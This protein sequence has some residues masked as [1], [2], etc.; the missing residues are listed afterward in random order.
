MKSKSFYYTLVITAIFI[1]I[2]LILAFTPI[3]FI[4]LGFIKATIIHIPVIIGSILLG[5]KIGAGLGAL[6]GLT[7]LISNTISPAVLSFVFSPLIP[8]PGTDSGSWL[9]LIIC[10][11]PRILV[12]IVPYYVYKLLLKIS[13]NKLRLDWVFLSVSGIVGSMV[14]T[15]LVMNLIFFLFHDSYAYVKSITV[16][17][18]YGAVMTVVAVNGI[19]EA[20]VAGIITAAMG[21]VLFKMKMNKKL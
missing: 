16:D 4:Q 12:G 17:M 14:N 21:K 1:A 19:P 6:F 13:K 9:S 8:V 11:I 2:I 10:F 7:S 18:V 5:P 15:L 3:G 20:I